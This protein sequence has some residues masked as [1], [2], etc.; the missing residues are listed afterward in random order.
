M[1]GGGLI[2]PHITEQVGWSP[3]L[4]FVIDTLAGIHLTHGQLIYT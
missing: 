3:D 4:T 2:L 1:G